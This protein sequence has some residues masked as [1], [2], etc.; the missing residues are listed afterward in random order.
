MG[1]RF[2]VAAWRGSYIIEFMSTANRQSTARRQF[3]PLSRHGG[4]CG[5]VVMRLI[6][7]VFEGGLLAAAGSMSQH[8]GNTAE[9]VELVMFSTG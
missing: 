3:V 6:G 7:A 2:A 4:L 1:V 8:I 5:D 9:N